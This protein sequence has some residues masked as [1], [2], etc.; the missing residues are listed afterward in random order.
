MLDLGYWYMNAL[1]TFRKDIGDTFD[2]SCVKY[3]YPSKRTIPTDGDA[4]KDIRHVA[5]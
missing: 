4:N 3:I 5:S 1:A 2:Q